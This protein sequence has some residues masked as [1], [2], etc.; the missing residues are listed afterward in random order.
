MFERAGEAEAAP[1]R[2][3]VVRHPFGIRIFRHA[4]SEASLVVL[5]GH[6]IAAFLALHLIRPYGFELG[7][8]ELIAGMVNGAAAGFGTRIGGSWG[9]R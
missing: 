9:D 2:A 1:S 3:D 6:G 5:V 8:V 4:V 7:E